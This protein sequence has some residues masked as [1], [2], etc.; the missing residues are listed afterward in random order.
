MLGI[1]AGYYETE[2]TGLG[3]PF[4]PMADR[5]A[6]QEETLQVCLQM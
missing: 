6:L 3:L 1:G 5:F 4:P 2:A